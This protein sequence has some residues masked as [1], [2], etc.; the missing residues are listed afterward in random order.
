MRRFLLTL[1]LCLLLVQRAQAQTA[2]GQINVSVRDGHNQPVA[3]QVVQFRAERGNVSA[4]C[5]TNA[6]GHCTIT[7]TTAPADPAGFIRGTL[8]A[9]DRGSRPLIWPAGRID[10]PLH[11]NAEGR[12]EMPLDVLA[13]RTPSPAP[14]TSSGTPASQQPA[15]VAPTT[16]TETDKQ[17][18]AP[19]AAA[20]ATA[21]STPASPSSRRLALFCLLFLGLIGASLYTAWRKEGQR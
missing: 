10:V 4:A 2:T 15:T 8:D 13:T 1:T 16:T 12:L 17:P 18:R 21:S 7:L 20:T 6:A 14:S 9:P 3:G 11:L 19:Q 5:T